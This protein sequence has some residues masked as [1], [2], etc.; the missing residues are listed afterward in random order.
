MLTKLIDTGLVLV[1]PKWDPWRPSSNHNAT[2]L[3]PRLGTSIEHPTFS[4]PAPLRPLCSQVTELSSNSLKP[5]RLLVA[6]TG[7][8]ALSGGLGASLRE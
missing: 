6:L 3:R 4:V 7:G 8:C 5:K 2:R 1:E